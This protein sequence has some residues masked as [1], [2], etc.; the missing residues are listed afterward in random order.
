MGQQ[1]LPDLALRVLPVDHRLEVPSQ[2]SPADLPACPNQV[3]VHSVPVGGEHPRSWSDQG[4]EGGPIAVGTNQKDRQGG[5]HRHPQPRL[6]LPLLPARFVDVCVLAPGLGQDIG[7]DRVQRP[8]DSL[9]QFAHGPK[10]HRQVAHVV[11]QRANGPLAQSANPAQV[12]HRRGQ[13]GAE[14]AGR[15]GHGGGDRRG[16]T[17]GTGQRMAAVVNHVSQLD[18]QVEHLVDSWV[19]VLT[20]E[21]RGTVT[22]MGR[23]VVD[24]FVGRE[25]HLLV[26]RVA[27]L[28]APLLARRCPGRGR[29]H[30]RAVGR[31]R[32]G[33]VR[34][35]LVEPG[36]EFGD[37][38]LEDGDLGGD[39]FERADVRLHDRRQGGERG[40]GEWRWRYHAAR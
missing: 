34:R 24:D 10:R 25:D 37:A 14:P 8:A 7:V 29:L 12:S 2:M 5:S 26:F 1:R 22:A 39:G 11:E 35:V 32:F 15:L 4:I 38:G 30:L 18:R 40:V 3:G 28:A 20:V 9:L 31:G 6:L 19:R 17:F 36:F 27:G 33:R 21:R 16:V 13:F 23:F